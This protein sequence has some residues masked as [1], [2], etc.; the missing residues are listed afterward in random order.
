M[1]TRL[2]SWSLKLFQIPKLKHSLL[3]EQMLLL[4]WIRGVTNFICL[5]DKAMM[6]EDLM[7]CGNLIFKQSFGPKSKFTGATS[8]LCLDQG[9]L[10][11][12]IRTNCLFLV[13]F[14]S[15]QK[16]LTIWFFTISKIESSNSPWEICI[17][18]PISLL[19]KTQVLMTNAF[20]NPLLCPGSHPMKCCRLV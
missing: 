9:T 11:S 20:L 6:T 19:D 8:S 4:A 3:Q 5:V 7:I 16:N 18:M 13:E 14:L 2:K 17:A 15:W 1:K 12:N 10:H